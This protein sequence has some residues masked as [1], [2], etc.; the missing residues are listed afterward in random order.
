MANET[1]E[2]YQRR[3]RRDRDSRRW[4]AMQDEANPEHW[5]YPMP[6]V[7]EVIAAGYRADF[8]EAVARDRAELVKQFLGDAE[9]RADLIAK[10]RAAR[11][12]AR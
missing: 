7:E 9:W 2:Q 10:M 5:I 12:A 6:T 11:A 3:R 4:P 1:Y 8:H